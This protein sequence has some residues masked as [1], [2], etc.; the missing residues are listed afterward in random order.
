MRHQQYCWCRINF[1][2]F[3]TTKLVLLSQEWV[4]FFLQKNHTIPGKVGHHGR[5]QFL[6]ETWVNRHVSAL[7]IF[8]F[9]RHFFV[10]KKF[11][12]CDFCASFFKI[13]F[14]IFVRRFSR[15]FAGARS[16]GKAPT[17][18]PDKAPT[19]QPDKAPTH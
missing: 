7:K 11:F 15:I 13:F 17:H 16:M 10:Q 19:H 6:N 9:F 3:N 12:F 1:L 5:G 8:N 14:A 4:S 2:V 18:Q